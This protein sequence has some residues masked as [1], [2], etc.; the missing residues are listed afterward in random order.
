M[1]EAVLRTADVPVCIVGPNVNEGSYHNLA[2]R[3]ILCDVSIREVSRVVA[4]FGAQ[5][6]ARHNAILTLQQMIRPQERAERLAGRTISQIEAE[7]RSL[8][9]EE[10]QANIRLRTKVV[11]GDPVEELLYEGRTQRA[12]LMVVG[13]PCASRFAA[14]TRAGTVYKLLAYA[15]CP[16]ITLS[17]IVL[18]ACGVKKNIPVPSEVH[19]L[20]GVI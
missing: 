12:N 13:A 9:P 14:I 17:P 2:T 8:I 11:V 4:S 19:Y 20:A 1:A 18:A 16:V 5:L 6:A 10:L 7:L 15:H 3:N